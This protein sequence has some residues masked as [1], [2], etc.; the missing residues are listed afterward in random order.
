MAAIEEKSDILLKEHLDAFDEKLGNQE[1]PEQIILN[2]CLYEA[3][4]NILDSFRPFGSNGLPAF[5]FESR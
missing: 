2:R 4:N 3:I 5:Y 1:V